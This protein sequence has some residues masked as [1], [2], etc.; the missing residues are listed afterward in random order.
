MYR[1]KRL[2]HHLKYKTDYQVAGSK[3]CDYMSLC[4]VQNTQ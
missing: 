3:Y 4:Y 1:G 2:Q